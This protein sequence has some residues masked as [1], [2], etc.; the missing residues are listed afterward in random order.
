MNLPVDECLK[1]RKGNVAGWNFIFFAKITKLKKVKTGKLNLV[2]SV[3][4]DARV[5][6]NTYKKKFFTTD[7]A[8]CP[9]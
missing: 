2:V 3:N 7:S 6:T 9:K 4:N 8:C 5:L 1:H